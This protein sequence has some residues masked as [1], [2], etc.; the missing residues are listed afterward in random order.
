MTNGFGEQ[1]LKIYPQILAYALSRTVNRADA[2]DLVQNAMIRALEKKKQFDGRSLE[3][4]VITIARN[5]HLDTVK[6]SWV[7]QKDGEEL[8]TS[9]IADGLG[10]SA[11][12][13][14]ALLNQVIEIIDTLGERCKTLLLLSAQGYKT[15]EIAEW[16]KI[17]AGTAGRGMMECRN[18]LNEAL[19][20][21]S[22]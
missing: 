10:I 14:T 9:A 22:S 1:L 6:S 20:A 5:L 3:G 16:L 13:S 7:K 12:E 18:G 8:D 21:R 4:W 11:A 15:R 17:P 19:S 2:E